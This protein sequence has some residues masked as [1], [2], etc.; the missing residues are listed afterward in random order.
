MSQISKEQLK[1][2][3]ED[4]LQ[5][6]EHPKFF[7]SNYFSDLR[8]QVDKEIKVK[9]IKEPNQERKNGLSDINLQ[10]IQRIESFEEE[11]NFLA[12]LLS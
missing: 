7:L 1:L 8:H 4:A 11:H 2:K 6:C 12:V 9:Q 3:L 5:A 10:L